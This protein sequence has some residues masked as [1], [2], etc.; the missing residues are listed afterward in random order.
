MYEISSISQDRTVGSYKRAPLV[1]DAA[2][3][4]FNPVFAGS[5]LPPAALFVA[6]G[7]AREAAGKR[8]ATPSV[9]QTD[10]HGGRRR[11]GLTRTSSQQRVVDLI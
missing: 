8:V 5:I 6:A 7:E 2:T 1:M 10:G 9:E 11:P 4:T 3:R